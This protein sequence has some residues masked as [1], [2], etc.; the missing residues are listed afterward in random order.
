MVTNNFPNLF[1]PFEIGPLKLKNRIVMPPMGTNFADLNAPGFISERHKSYYAERA[2]G[3]VG[4]IIF[5]GTRV[6]PNR[7]ARKGGPDLHGDQ[8]IPG[9]QEL[10]GL[11]KDGGARCAV[12]I[13]DRGRVG[14]LK[15]DF[16]GK[17]DASDT[18][19]GE[20][21]GAS[22]RPHPMSGVV[23]EELGTK[24]LEQIAGYF[25]DAARRAKMAGFDAVELHGAHGVLLNEFLSPYSNKRTDQYGGD[26]QGRS[27]FPLMVV[28]RVREALGADL[29]LSYRM[30]V[31][32]FVEGGM[33]IG[34]SIL[35]AKMLEAEGVQV[36]HVSAGINETP[37]A[38]NRAIPPMSFERGRLFPYSEQLKKAL[39]IPVL[40]VQR[41]TTPELAEEA[42]REGKADLVAT[43]RALIADPYWPLKAMEGRVN[44]IRRCCS[45]SQ[46]C[47]ERLI[48]EQPMTC[49]QNPE[50]GF[51]AIY[52]PMLK[53]S[54][55][56][57]KK[58]V[59]VIGGGLAGMEAA[60]VCAS[61][62]HEVRLVEKEGQLGGMA[63]L[64]SI[65]ESKRE[66]SGVVEF[67]ENQLK[68][69]NVDVRLNEEVT[70]QAVKDADFDEIILATGSLPVVPDNLRTCA[71]DV[72]LAKYVLEHPEDVGREVVILGGGSVG[73][74][75][76][77]F[78]HRLG[79]K[80]TVI[81]M[82]DMICRDQGPLRRADM[83]ERI[84]KT[85]VS[86]MLKTTVQD[87]TET[88]IRISRDGKVDILKL[89]DT[90]VVAVGA[91]PNSISLPGVGRI[92]TVG[93]CR[94]VGNAMAAIHDAFE[95]AIHL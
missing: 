58:R 8:F 11:I 26:L 31:V 9:F 78:L 51:E 27:R 59:L 68:E 79:K 54:E 12:Q 38:M 52:R 6:N 94:K 67:L 93:D 73:I 88:G 13:S 40:V 63:R 5:E 24:E 95:V 70:T 71:C 42:I 69:F 87:V 30:S 44:E 20:Y 61:K 21:V 55:A 76:A 45:C 57:T 23:A 15:V 10:V 89:P 65:V 62:G 33:E 82:M 2:M 28:R 14:N 7:L 64:A 37:S 34:E 3:G 32:E 48:Q 46:G 56:K 49:L 36:L 43:G 81:E 29:V 84:Q 22:A 39:R 85:D 66:F 92:H 83:I 1:Q 19:Q 86:I 50:V 75:V 25:A 80:V 74:E 17:F 4:L 91:K 53:K 16:S 47:I 77:E 90:V 60:C 41:I 35:F 72:R 18:K